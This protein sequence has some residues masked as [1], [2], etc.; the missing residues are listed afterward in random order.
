MTA[1]TLSYEYNNLESPCNVWI[2]EDVA[3]SPPLEL[4]SYLKD[5]IENRKRKIWSVNYLN[6][7]LFLDIWHYITKRTAA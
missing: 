6:A 7:F 5:R 2:N 3:G 1:A 4:P